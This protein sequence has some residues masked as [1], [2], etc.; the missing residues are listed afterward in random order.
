MHKIGDIETFGD[1]RCE[2]VVERGAYMCDGCMF[3]SNG[4]CAICKTKKT[5]CGRMIWQPTTEQPPI[6]PPTDIARINAQILA[7]K[8]EQLLR[9][10][11]FANHLRIDLVSADH[12]GDDWNIRINSDL[13]K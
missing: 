13:A 1:K 4:G 8:L 2:A 6:P 7:N 3:E 9:G 11:E 10:Y 5:A 12:S